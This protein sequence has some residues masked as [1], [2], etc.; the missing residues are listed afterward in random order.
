MKTI[1]V[2]WGMLLALIACKKE[3]EV[4]APELQVGQV[5][6]LLHGK[7]WHEDIAVKVTRF[8]ET[9]QCES[10]KGT[11][12]IHFERFALT[13]QRDS[14]LIESLFFSKIPRKIGRYPIKETIVTP[15]NAYC[16][17]YNANASFTILEGDVGTASYYAKKDEPGFLEI[18]DFNADTGI[19]EG[20]FELT[21]E[22]YWKGITP[23][24]DIVRFTKGQFKAKVK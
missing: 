5:F 17:D 1:V 8:N 15:A 14:L 18:T 3:Q 4:V 2:V 13:Q 6:A 20:T 12:S 21:V 22:V 10:A 24:P 23:Y 7:R 9:S 11:W 19:V 16:Q